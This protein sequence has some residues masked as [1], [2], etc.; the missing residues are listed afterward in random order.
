MHNETLEKIQILLN[1]Q[2]YETYSCTITE[3]LGELKINKN[4]ALARN[5]RVVHAKEW[6]SVKLEKD[7]EIE[8]LH[9]VGGG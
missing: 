5:S 4:I 2:V 7:D 8:I 1:G 3:L 6:D 9:F